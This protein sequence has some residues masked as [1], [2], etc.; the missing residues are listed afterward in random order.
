MAIDMTGI[1][2]SFK[3]SNKASKAPKVDAW[4]HTPLPDLSTE[5]NNPVKSSMT[6]SMSSSSSS[7]GPTNKSR[8]PAT[9][10]SKSLAAIL[11]PRAALTSL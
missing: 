7:S 8:E 3:K 6:S 4:T 1:F 11:T 5:S 2:I 9:A 10:C